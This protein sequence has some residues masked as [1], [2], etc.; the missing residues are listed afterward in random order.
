M[1]EQGRGT[2]GSKAGAYGDEAPGPHPG[3]DHSG[4]GEP[5]PPEAGAAAPAP[6]GHFGDGADEAAVAAA[7]HEG[8]E[9]R[10]NG[11][12]DGR[13]VDASLTVAAVAGVTGGGGAGGRLRRRRRLLRP[14]LA[15]RRR[16]GGGEWPCSGMRIHRALC[17][18]WLQNKACARWRGGWWKAA[19]RR[20]S[21]PWLEGVG[22]AGLEGSS[23][24]D[25]LKWAAP[26]SGC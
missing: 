6:R 8:R 14:P 2:K 3:A 22:S 23:S 9:L 17:L 25:G 26:V 7:R 24:A 21:K 5:E 15:L 12:G 4:L 16:H 20:T 11:G 13:E 10:C 18:D 19:R 1:R